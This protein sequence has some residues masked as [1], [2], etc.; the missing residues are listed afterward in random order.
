[1]QDVQPRLPL[2]AILRFHAVV[3]E[4]LVRHGFESDAETG[5]YSRSRVSELD[6]WVWLP[7]DFTH[8]SR[9]GGGVRITANLAIFCE[10]LADWLRQE[11]PTNASHLAT[12]TRN[13]GYLMPERRWKEW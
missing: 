6:D 5:I 4:K 12:L 1:M 8:D 7:V 11:H 2:D 9:E 13:I 10:P 3:Q